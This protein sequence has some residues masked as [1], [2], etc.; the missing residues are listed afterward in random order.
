MG[1]MFFVMAIMGC[2]DDGAA[3]QA[4]RIEPTRY[5]TVAQCR[6]ALPAALARNTDLSFPVIQADCQQ[7]GVRYYAERAGKQN[8]FGPVG[9]LGGGA[10]IFLQIGIDAR[11]DFGG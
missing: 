5:A 2:G 3:C 9:K 1:P 11:R 10:E 8:S 7:R 4:A 6:A